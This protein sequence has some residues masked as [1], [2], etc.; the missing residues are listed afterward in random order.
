MEDEIYAECRDALMYNRI[1]TGIIRQQESASQR[2]RSL[3]YLY[4]NHACIE[5]ITRSR[6]LQPEDTESLLSRDKKAWE[7]RWEAT[8]KMRE[9]PPGSSSLPKPCIGNFLGSSIF[10]A[11]DDGIFALD[12]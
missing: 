7:K 2:P 8:R 6:Y 9:S 4:E 5:N 12:F 3:D 1:V 11:E 10:G